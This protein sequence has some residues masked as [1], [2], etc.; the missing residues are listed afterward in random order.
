M[1]GMVEDRGV[2]GNQSLPKESQSVTLVTP[3]P[4][5]IS[6]RE[7]YLAPVSTVFMA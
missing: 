5:S 2:A 3:C 4:V 7:R 1:Q 6:G